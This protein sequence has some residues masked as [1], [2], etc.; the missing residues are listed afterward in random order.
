MSATKSQM[1]LLGITGEVLT[2][3]HDKAPSEVYEFA[4]YVFSIEREIVSES[5]F[6]ET[7][8]ASNGLIVI[9][10]EAIESIRIHLKKFLIVGLNDGRRVHF[11]FYDSRVLVDFLPTC[12]SAQLSEF[13]GP[14]LVFAVQGG[15]EGDWLTFRLRGGEVQTDIVQ[16]LCAF[17]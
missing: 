10:D 12:N 6:R 8:S 1:G 7:F 15:R 2:L 4:P 14:I 17:E 11:R 16:G 13:F 9:S 5:A 3:F